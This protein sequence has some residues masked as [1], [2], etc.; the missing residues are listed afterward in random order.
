MHEDPGV[1]SRIE[2]SVGWRSANLPVDRPDPGP[3]RPKSGFGNRAVGKH[4]RDVQSV[5]GIV[6]NDSKNVP[7]AM[8]ESVILCQQ[9]PKQGAECQTAI[10]NLPDGVPRNAVHCRRLYVKTT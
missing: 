1:G 7:E 3:M 6:G 5:Q 4:G 2:H 8:P 9:G 10:K